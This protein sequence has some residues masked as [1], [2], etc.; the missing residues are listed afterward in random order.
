[1]EIKSLAATGSEE[2]FEAFDRAFADYDID[3]DRTSLQRMLRRR[4]FTPELSFAAF[5]GGR[6]VSFTFNGTGRRDGIATAYDTGT[7]T[8]PEYRGQGLAQRIFAHSVPHLRAA[9]I[10]QYLLE[11]LQHN[12]GAIAVYR[13][14]GFDTVRE[15]DY[16]AQEKSLLHTATPDCGLAIRDIALEDA[17]AVSCFCDFEPSWQ[18]DFDSALRAGG[19]MRCRGAIAGGELAGYC[20][21]E[22]ASGDIAQIAVAPEHRRRGIGRALLADAAVLGDGPTVKVI[23]TDSRCE[24]IAEFLR[25]TNIRLRGRQFEMLKQ[26]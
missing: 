22:P 4:G 12:P 16:Y 20:I 13:K 1:M 3:L 26:L 23:N 24:S 2:L 21:S 11:V 6:I 5:D 14:A 18:N 15:L 25:K 7:G 10:R 9:G 19:D 17:R 8:I